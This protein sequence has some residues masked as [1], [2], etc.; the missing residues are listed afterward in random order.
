[1]KWKFWENEPFPYDTQNGTV[2]G[3]TRKRGRP[4]KKTAILPNAEG[5][6][7]ADMSATDTDENEISAEIPISSISAPTTTVYSNGPTVWTESL[8]GY[9][10]NGSRPITSD[11]WH[12]L[13]SPWKERL[14][15]LAMGVGEH[16]NALVADIAEYYVGEQADQSEWQLLDVVKHYLDN[17]LL[18]T[19]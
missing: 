4:A 18:P 15:E 13:P 19:R 7:T 12:M 16:P 2:S 5:L 14:L 17:E 9:V 3:E 8:I 11:E 6:S 1:V 10:E